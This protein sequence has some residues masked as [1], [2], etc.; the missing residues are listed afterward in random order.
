MTRL[1]P[2]AA[3]AVSGDAGRG[4]D[5]RRAAPLFSKPPA[6]PQRQHLGGWHRPGDERGG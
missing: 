5:G 3:V 6:Q 1:L 4:P 2:I